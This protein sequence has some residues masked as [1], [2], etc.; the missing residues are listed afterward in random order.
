MAETAAHLADRV[1]AFDRR[2]Y[3]AQAVVRYF[4]TLDQVSEG[5]FGKMHRRMSA[6]SDA[7]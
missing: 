5:E 6:I 3:T 2:G 1:G 4:A 7:S